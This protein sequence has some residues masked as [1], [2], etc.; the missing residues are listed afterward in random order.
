M[1]RP[2]PQPVA[3]T[4]APRRDLCA[5]LFA[6]PERLETALT[7]QIDSPFHVAP[8]VHDRLLQLDVIDG[9]SGTTWLDGHR[10]ELHDLSVM[11]TRPERSHG[12]ELL[13]GRE[14][15]RVY[16]IKLRV[17]WDWSVARQG[18]MPALM[19]GLAPRAAL[20][21][22]AQAVVRFASLASPPVA[23][24][25][26]RL[27]EA[28]ALWPA[29]DDADRPPVPDSEDPQLTPAIR[30]IEARPADPPSVEEL[31]EATCLS[32]R[33]FA[34][35]FKRAFAATPHDVITARRLQHAKQ[36]LLGRR[37]LVNQVADRLGFSSMATFSRWFSHE[38]GV[39]PSRYQSDPSTL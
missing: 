5:K 27:A 17:E 2:A 30:L 1:V 3:D 21:D 10:H 14:P 7:H 8:H 26:A 28:V 39:P 22:A 33:H 23:L 15:S 31:A 12:Y 35:R 25:L 6:E 16:V 18:G 20:A 4:L 11:V 32:P 38:T 13:P 29:E 19:T 36:L 37:L 9:C 24:M 34:R